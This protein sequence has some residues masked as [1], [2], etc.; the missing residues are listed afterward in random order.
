MRRPAE[1]E[2]FDS[3][4]LPRSELICRRGE[5][6]CRRRLNTDP[7]SPVESCP[8]WTWARASAGTSSLTR[9]SDRVRRGRGVSGGEVG[10]DQGDAPGRG[11][12]DQGGRE[13]DRALAQHD[14]RGAAQPEAAV[15]WAA[16]AAV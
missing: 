4:L 6:R 14:P 9:S 7:L 11:A 16:G 2:A 10:R 1:Q 5:T 15:V 13:A 3:V 12:F 8:P